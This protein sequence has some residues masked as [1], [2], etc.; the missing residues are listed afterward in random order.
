MYK[1]EISCIETPA[2]LKSFR[3]RNE[4]PQTKF[5]QPPARLVYTEPSSPISLGKEDY[6]II[7]FGYED[8]EKD[9]IIQKLQKYGIIDYIKDISRYCIGVRYREIKSANNALNMNGQVILENRMI[10]V[11]MLNKT[12]TRR[13]NNF[14][15]LNEDPYLN[16]YQVRKP[17]RKHNIWDKIKT[18]VFNFND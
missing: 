14:T 10:G 11:M 3:S 1:S 17:R 5:H 15:Y 16:S 7:V 2:V 6:Q 18:Y 13:E 8:G 9:K 12:E 4:S